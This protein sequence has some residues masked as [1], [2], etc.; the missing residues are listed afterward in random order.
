MKNKTGI[1]IGFAF[2]IAGFLFLFK[3]LALP[4]IPPEDELAPGIVV[5]VSIVSGIFFAFMGN[6][7]QNYLGKKEENYK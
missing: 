3:I 5:L 6:S 4:H 7:I 1:I 2:G